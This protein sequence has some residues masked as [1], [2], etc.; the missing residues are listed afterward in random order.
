MKQIKESTRY[1]DEVWTL[2][3]SYTVIRILGEFCKSPFLIDGNG[4][5]AQNTLL[6]A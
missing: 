1:F 6:I 5:A 3:L 2:R 4:D